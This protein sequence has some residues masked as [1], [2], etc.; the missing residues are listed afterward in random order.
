MV[1]REKKAEQFSLHFVSRRVWRGGL[2]YNWKNPILNGGSL[3][4]DA[5]PPIETLFFGDVFE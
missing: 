3:Q 1:K 4:S 5:C 2:D